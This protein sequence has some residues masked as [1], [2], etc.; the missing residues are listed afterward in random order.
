MRAIC[1]SPSNDQSRLTLALLDAV[2]LSTD[3]KHSLSWAYGAFL[4][5][6]PKRLDISEALDIAARVLGF[7]T[8]LLLNP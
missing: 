6:V 8:P 4:A 3:L 7:L 1:Q 2:K 5:D